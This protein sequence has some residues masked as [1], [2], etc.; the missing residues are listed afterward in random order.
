MFFSRQ[1]RGFTLVELLVVIAI[2]GILVA[3]LLPAVQSARQAA[4]RMS[5]QSKMRQVAIATLN[6]ESARQR[7]PLAN[8]LVEVDGTNRTWPTSEQLVGPDFGTPA[9]DGSADRVGGFSYLVRLLP[10]IEEQALFDAIRGTSGNFQRTAFDKDVADPAGVHWASSR[11]TSFICP[12]F[13]GDDFAD[14]DRYDGTESAAGNYLAV[15]GSHL[16]STSLGVDYNGVIVPATAANR[17]RGVGFGGI[18]DGGSKT[19]LVVESREAAVNAWYDASSTWMIL[20][21]P[22]D[23][24]ALTATGLNVGPDPNAATSRN[25]Y[26]SFPG[27]PRMWG[28]SSEHGGLAIHAFAD[29]HTVSITDNVDPIVYA[30]I[31]TRNGGESVQLP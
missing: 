23:A 29:A 16:E 3:L 18:S 10:Y 22:E 2:I 28:P 24:D 15:V 31:A 20:M 9:L 13:S 21:D 7:F 25:F 6:F 30:A 19:V 8:D 12:A 17:G 11:V 14:E 1:R 4:W 27:G 26:E 5:C